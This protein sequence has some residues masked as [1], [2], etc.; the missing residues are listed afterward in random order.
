MTK[1]ASQAEQEE[2]GKEEEK[3]GTLPDISPRKEPPSS[4]SRQGESGVTID[5]YFVS[6]KFIIRYRNI[7]TGILST[8]LILPSQNYFLFF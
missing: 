7:V 4:C 5:P 6:V 8:F 1:A 3:N 2:G